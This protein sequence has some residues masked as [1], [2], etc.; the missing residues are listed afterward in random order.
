MIAYLHFVF[1]NTSSVGY[2][3][4]LPRSEYLPHWALENAILKIE[5][6]KRAG[7][8]LGDRNELGDRNM[9]L[10]RNVLGDRNVLLDRNVLC[11]RNELGDRSGLVDRGD[12]FGL[13]DRNVLGDRNNLRPLRVQRYKKQKTLTP[14]GF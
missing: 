10:D 5:R 11:D 2:G 14:L 12:R 6:F 7:E 4:G 9:L 13:G 1:E 8:W 3:G